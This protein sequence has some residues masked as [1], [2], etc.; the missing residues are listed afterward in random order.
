MHQD[1]L[2]SR[3][4]LLWVVAFFFGLGLVVYGRSLT[5]DFV[6]WDDGMLIYENPAV[7]EM[8]PWSMK[9][10]FTTYDPELYIPAT[11]ITYQ[12]DYKIWGANPF[13]YH[14]TSLLLHIGN[15]IL[16]AWLAFLLLRHRW[17]ALLCGLL[18]LLHPLHTEAVSWAS[19]RKDVLSTLF[20][21]S[22]L[23]AYLRYQEEEERRLYIWSLVFFALGLMSKV[24]VIT[25]PAILLL[26]DWRNRRAWTAMI[27]D[28]L[29]YVGLSIL[30][31]IIA[32]FGKTA[33][34]AS[35]TLSQKIL[36]ACK[37]TVFYL[38]AIAWP[39]KLSLLYPYVGEITFASPDFYV[40]VLV[41]AAMVLIAVFASIRWRDVTLAIV[42]YLLTLVPTFINFAKGGELDIYFASDRYAYI[43][44]IGM[45]YLFCFL[46]AALLHAKRHWERAV[47]AV[48]AA[49][50]VVLGVAA[51][52]QSLVWRDT[53]SLFANVLAYYP[54]SSHVA[55]NNLGNMHRLRGEID[56]SIE[57]YKQAISIRP[58]AKT[59]SNLGAAYRKQ[60][61]M[62]E[63]LAAYREA[64]KVDPKS[65][66]AHIGLGIIYVEQGNAAQAEAEYKEGLRY[67]PTEE[68]GWTNLGVLY[69]N[70][71]RFNEAVDAYRRAL[72][73]NPYFA[74]AQYNL[75]V[76]LSKK[77]DIDGAI[78]AYG[79]VTHIAPSFI[80]ARMNL[81]LLLYKNGDT[82]AARRQFQ[83][84]LQIDPGNRVARQA[85][86][87]M[88]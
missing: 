71:N 57:E 67:D 86:E 47:Q 8:S 70:Q 53:E 17:V 56:K 45:F 58:H 77:G 50:V 43:P 16:V 15:A 6:R 9:R 81:A 30:F 68:I 3:R 48:G 73:V 10:I 34:V 4:I 40:P 49:I 38:Q 25:L 60:G 69:T 12:I 82:R 32:I 24:M 72:A 78:D 33:V 23:I 54:D 55:H 42:F 62:Q 2:P 76:A 36:M 52:R 63:A 21:L 64:L 80:A 65:A 5:N 18:F 31:G 27:K 37:S 83:T 51:Y 26:V 41:V 61:R 87:Q 59:Y 1:A 22:S 14:L 85:L 7:R 28:K 46:L 74:D 88:Q 75:G 13:G 44:S 20:F 39:S 29:P 79:E 35:S 19:G 84:I 66:L 11:F